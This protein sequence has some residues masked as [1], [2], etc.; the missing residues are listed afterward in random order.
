MLVI[1]DD[2]FAGL[3]A[4]TEEIVFNKLLGKQGLLR[5][6]E[7]TVIL[8]TH[9]VHRLPYADHIIALD[10][11]GRI[12]EQGSF[13][14]L[15]ASNG[16]IASIATKHRYE[17]SRSNDETEVHLSSTEP[18]IRIIELEG[19][20]TLDADIIRPNGEFSTYKYYFGSIGWSRSLL[21]ALILALSGISVKLT[22][23]ILTYWTGAIAVHG[24]EVNSYYLG[25]YSMLA[26]LSIF[27]FNYGIY[28]FFLS[29]VPRS[30]E[31]LHAR[32]LRAVMGA[33]LHFF[34]STDTGTTT[35]RLVESHFFFHR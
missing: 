24:N 22:E 21:S 17:G 7:T 16:Y 31:E 28:H 11:H 12:A 25:L 3:D 29:V 2:A 6:S 4:E 32:L 15:R 18:Q 27:T 30:A 13:E 19:A 35:N 23:L 8:V 33:P 14:R 10:A 1:I 5:R 9:A 20:K 26:G 34:S